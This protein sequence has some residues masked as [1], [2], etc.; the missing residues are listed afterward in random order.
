MGQHGFA[1]NEAWTVAAQSADEVTLHLVANEATKAVFP[2]DF[3]VTLRYALRGRILRIE[4]RI[5]T[6]G[7][8][9]PFGAGFHPYFFIPDNEKSRVR[10]PTPATRAWDNVQKTDITIDG[11]IDF[12][13]P[14]VDLR[15][16]DHGGTDATLELGKGRKIDI[17]ASE[18]LRHWVIWTLGGRDFVCLEPWTAP[19]N[20]LNSGKDLLVATRERPV[21]LWVEIDA[22][23][24]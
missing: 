15:L 5:E 12:G 1:R 19:P 14:E 4:Q 24:A 10:V 16:H 6:R 2:W 18:A 7:E 22:S 21:T 8:D 23:T 13:R 3:E 9:M 20:A 11:P 17:R